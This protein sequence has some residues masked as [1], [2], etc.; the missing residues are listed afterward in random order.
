MDNTEE[1]RLQAEILDLRQLLAKAGLDIAA[2]EAADKL[3]YV[4]MEEVNHRLK[5]AIATVAAIVDQ[6]LRNSPTIEE[7]REAVRIRLNTLARTHDLLAKKGAHGV[8]LSE[9]VATSIAPF[10]EP[11]SHQFLFHGLG[12]EITPEAVQPLALVFNELCT[13][14]IK[15]GALSTD[16]GQVHIRQTVK[17]DV[18]D[19]IWAERKGPAVLAPKRLGFGWRLIESMAKQ[20]NGTANL[21]FEPMGVVCKLAIPIDALRPSAE[22]RHY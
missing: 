5:N 10:L 11:K 2:H 6:S 17:G 7:G 14:S 1:L 21:K 18:R 16:S 12:F 4:L 8:E 9:V 20:L 15:Y 19:L 3:H 13:N 22:V